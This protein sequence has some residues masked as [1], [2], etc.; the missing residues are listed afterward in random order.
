MI[1]KETTKN[2]SQLIQALCSIEETKDLTTS[3]LLFSF[4]VVHDTVGGGDNQESE[5][6]GGKDIVAPLFV[7]IKLEIESGGDDTALV[8]STK[9][10]ND[11]FIGSVVIDDFE[12]TN[13]TVLLHDSEESDDDS[14]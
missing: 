8:D 1:R 9:K 6:S 12:F 4:F 2:L 11:D 10:L 14:G 5:L 7:V 3:L 13:V